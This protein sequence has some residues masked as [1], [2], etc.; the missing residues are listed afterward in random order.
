MKTK[1]KT[2]IF[3]LIIACLFAGAFSCCAAETNINDYLGVWYLDAVYNLE[4]GSFG[5]DY[6]YPAEYGV[7][8][9]M[10]LL[11]DGTAQYMVSPYDSSFDN[12]RTDLIDVMYPTGNRSLEIK[13][14][15]L[16][17]IN[18][19]GIPTHIFSKTSAKEW[20][21]EEINEEADVH[22]FAGKWNLVAM[23]QIDEGVIGFSSINESLLKS[24]ARMCVKNWAGEDNSSSFLDYS[25]YESEESG[26]SDGVY[27]FMPGKTPETDF[28]EK[29]FASFKDKP[30]IKILTT[31]EENQD[32]LYQ[33]SYRI[34]YSNNYLA[35]FRVLYTP[36]EWEDGVDPTEGA[37]YSRI[38]LYERS[39]QQDK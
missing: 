29:K 4:N 19:D 9:M 36:D 26:L 20:Y 5:E 3:I 32:G 15:K 28:S 2:T 23:Y 22:D 16:Y 12:S 24:A 18:E 21:L 33:V 7:T 27:S 17:S 39:V 38:W 11:S 10:V 13:D 1:I 31:G 25:M 8:A 37:I 35:V 34:L 30:G 14:G 6:F